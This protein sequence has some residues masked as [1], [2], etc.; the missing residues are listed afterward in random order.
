MH[1]SNITIHVER[2]IKTMN[3]QVASN[4]YP[5]VPIEVMNQF[6]ENFVKGYLMI[7]YGDDSKVEFYLKFNESSP[8]LTLFHE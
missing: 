4:V 8:T 6:E 5:N 7:D 1:Q 2:P 3:A